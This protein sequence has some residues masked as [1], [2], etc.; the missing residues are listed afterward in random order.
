MEVLKLI[1]LDVQ[2][3]ISL[4]KFITERFYYEKSVDINVS[5]E[6]EE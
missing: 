2:L 1:T 3:F 5:E 6:H 4:D